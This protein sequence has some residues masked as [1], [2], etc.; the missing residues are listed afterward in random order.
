MPEKL[1]LK[2]ITFSAIAVLLFVI[3]S[4]IHQNRAEA[5]GRNDYQS[6]SIRTV[7][8]TLQGLNEHRVREASQTFSTMPGIIEITLQPEQKQAIV[9]VDIDQLSM[10]TMEKT[11]Q[12]SGFTPLF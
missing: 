4:Y 10:K 12:S 11:L 5:I 7:R 2:M 8:M 6:D 3:L 9:R 1:Q